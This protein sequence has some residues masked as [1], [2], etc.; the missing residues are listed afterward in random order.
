MPSASR[1]PGPAPSRSTPVPAATSTPRWCERALGSLDPADGSLL[2]VEN[3]GNLVCPALFDVGEHRRVVVV[4]VTEGDD[5]PLKYPQMFAGA[6]LVVVNK[7]D[8]LP[9]VDCR[10]RRGHQER[11][12]RQPRR[13]RAAAVRA[14]RRRHGRLVRVARDP[15]QPLRPKETRWTPTTP[16]TWPSGSTRCSTRSGG[17]TTPAVNGAGRGAGAVLV[18]LYGAGLERAVELVAGPDDPDRLRTLADDD[19][20]GSAAGPARPAP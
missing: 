16:G 13:R 20:V 9:Y 5:K 11:P 18:G 3:V 8:L 14:R 15:D 17:A 2:F 12:R 19:L 10:P 1:A 4:S 7:T 6:D